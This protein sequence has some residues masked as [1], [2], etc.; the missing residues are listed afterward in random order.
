MPWQH[1]KNRRNEVIFLIRRGNLYLNAATVNGAYA[2]GFSNMYGS[3]TRGKKANIIITKPMD[4]Y[5]QIPYEFAHDPIDTVIIN[6]QVL[7]K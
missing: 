4:S 7:V 5:A 3:I 6:G 2:M 1:I